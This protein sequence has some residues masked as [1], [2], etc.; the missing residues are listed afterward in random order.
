MIGLT[1][2][3]GEL[4]FVVGL[5]LALYD[6]SLA[7]HIA[8]SQ[9]FADVRARD[10]RGLLVSGHLLDDPFGTSVLVASC[11]KKCEEEGGAWAS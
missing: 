8:P 4:L 10:D 9:T 3:L 6:T 5:A 2:L 7:R 11:R 1:N